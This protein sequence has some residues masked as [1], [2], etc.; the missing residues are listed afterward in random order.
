MALS[1]LWPALAFSS[2][3]NA[4]RDALGF[5]RNATRIIEGSS[6]LGRLAALPSY[7][8]FGRSS[9]RFI[10]GLVQ[11]MNDL[12]RRHVPFRLQGRNDFQTRALRC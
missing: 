2:A 11:L 7:D 3:M 8:R 4:S 10:S 5:L 9:P 1:A 6:P 12:E